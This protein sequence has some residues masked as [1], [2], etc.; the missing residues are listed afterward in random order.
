MAV[1]YVRTGEE[2]E[3]KNERKDFVKWEHLPCG[4]SQGGGG[5][6]GGGGGGGRGVKEHEK[7]ESF[8]MNVHFSLESGTRRRRRRRRGGGR[9]IRGDGA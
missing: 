8:Y 9:R 7:R 4:R 6:G 1:L 3:E 5:R 2:E